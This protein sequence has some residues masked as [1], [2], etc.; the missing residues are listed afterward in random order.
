MPE[1]D[2][3]A[4]RVIQEGLTNVMKHGRDAVVTINVRHGPE[5]AVLE[6]ISDG[7]TEPDPGASPPPTANRGGRGLSGLK[8]RVDELGGRLAAG[9][10]AQG[11]F[12]VRADLPYDVTHSRA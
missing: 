3:T 7:A 4:Y 1:V 2:H 11:G 8:S 9:P 5:S 6:V 12:E 10:R